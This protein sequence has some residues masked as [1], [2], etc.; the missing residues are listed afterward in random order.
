[1]SAAGA[2]HR[3]IDIRHQC[4]NC[5]VMFLQRSQAPSDASGIMNI[6]WHRSMRIVAVIRS[7]LWNGSVLYK[8][9]NVAIARKAYLRSIIRRVGFLNGSFRWL[10]IRVYRCFTQIPTL[11]RF[12]AKW[13]LHN[14]A[15][16]KKDLLAGQHNK[17]KHPTRN[18]KAVSMPLNKCGGGRG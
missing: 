9:D 2:G 15:I 8:I 1:M 10:V 7:R 17:K 3:V 14:F 11:K 13:K 12:E 5:G 16:H 4:S 18:I 6:V